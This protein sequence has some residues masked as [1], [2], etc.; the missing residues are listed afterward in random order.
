MKL[1]FS[2]LPTVFCMLFIGHYKNKQKVV[3]LNLNGA[4]RFYA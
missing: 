3:G 2:E 1:H 4:L